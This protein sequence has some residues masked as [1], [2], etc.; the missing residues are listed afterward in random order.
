MTC[1]NIS[2]PMF[3]DRQVTTPE[4]DDLGFLTAPLEPPMPDHDIVIRA[5]DG[6]VMR[7]FPDPD[8]IP[9]PTFREIQERIDMSAA[10]SSMARMREA[11]GRMAEMLEALPRFEVPRGGGI[12]YEPG[13]IPPSYRK[14]DP[15]Q[16]E[17]VSVHFLTPG[18]RVYVLED[19]FTVDRV[20][21]N[22][23]LPTVWLKELPTSPL[24]FSEE[25]SIYLAN[26]TED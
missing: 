5:A 23:I 6:T 1:G 2:K 7:Q 17:E 11:F 18:A 24:Y 3:F 25:E 14:R 8:I 19:V 22:A 26:E 13:W 10:E 12:S 16:G 20:D 4:W 21:M 15:R 9:R